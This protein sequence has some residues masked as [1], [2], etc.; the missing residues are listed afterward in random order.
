MARSVY[1]VHMRPKF[2][3][4]RTAVITFFITSVPLFG[5]LHWYTAGHDLWF[6][7]LAIQ[8]TLAAACAL[9]FWRQTTVFSGLTATTL[10]GS[11]I[12][13]PR[14]V[15]PLDE[16]QQIVFVPVYRS[17][18]DDA[19]VQFLALNR[20]GYCVF[21]MRG[22]FWH[23]S[24]LDEI[25]RATGREIVVE[26]VPLLEK[27]FFADYP[28][29]AYWF[30]KSPAVRVALVVATV[31]LVSGSVLLLASLIGLPLLRIR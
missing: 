12:F 18:P 1:L 27:E 10:E 22:H 13:S 8:V 28:G 21:R 19:S 26:R 31:I 11:G 29:S 24:D 16:V 25:A 2:A 7:L 17:Q 30:E 3:L 23:D 4:M 9:V 15:V 14:T 5:V 6:E 20:D